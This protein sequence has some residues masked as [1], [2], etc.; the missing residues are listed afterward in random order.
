MCKKVIE[1]IENSKNSKFFEEIWS[2]TLLFCEKFD[3]EEPVLHRKRQP[4]K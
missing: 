2:Q 4:N 3:I 1:N